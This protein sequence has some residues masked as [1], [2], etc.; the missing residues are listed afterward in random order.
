MV[1]VLNVKEIRVGLYGKTVS[2]PHACPIQCLVDSIKK[3]IDKFGPLEINLQGGGQII[4]RGQ[5]STFIIDDTGLLKEH[6]G[7]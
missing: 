6:F 3:E 2:L 1:A 7:V 5:D 4:K